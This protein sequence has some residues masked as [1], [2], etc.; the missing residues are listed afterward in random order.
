MFWE[1]SEVRN[2]C[3]L[4]K[5]LNLIEPKRVNPRF[6]D[7]LLGAIWHSLLM[8]PNI[9]HPLSM[10]LKKSKSCTTPWILGLF[11]LTK[12]HSPSYHLFV[13]LGMLQFLNL[14]KK[15]F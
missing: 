6:G 12:R 4:L 15:Q 3:G 11:G 2:P 13:Q 7:E 9:K 14:R 8:S 1:L 5:H 10:V